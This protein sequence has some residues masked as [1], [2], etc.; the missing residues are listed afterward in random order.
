MRLIGQHQ[1]NWLVSRNSNETNLHYRSKFILFL[2]TLIRRIS[3]HLLQWYFFFYHFFLNK[4]H[5]SK[6]IKQYAMQINM[7]I[8]C[9]TETDSMGKHTKRINHR[10]RWQRYT[11]RMCYNKRR[12]IFEHYWAYI[13][14][15]GTI[16]DRFCQRMLIFLLKHK[17]D[18]NNNN[19]HQILEWRHAL[20]IF[21]LQR[22]R[23]PH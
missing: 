15:A 11:N 20:K 2:V 12:Q 22:T 8:V 6:H 7:S 21:I 5:F 17:F 9:R 10:L 23:S 3:Y 16:K 19:T 14:Y 18:S 13:K 4:N 1:S